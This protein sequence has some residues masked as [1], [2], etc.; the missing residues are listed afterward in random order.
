MARLYRID[1]NNTL[2]TL[3][4]P[5]FRRFFLLCM[6]CLLLYYVVHKQQRRF[7]EV[8]LPSGHIPALPRQ[9]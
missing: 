2:N 4:S 7:S 3:S 6:L 5:L 1:W 8:G 9:G